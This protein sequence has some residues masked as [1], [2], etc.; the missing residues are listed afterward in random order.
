MI[1]NSAPPVRPDWNAT[2]AAAD[3]LRQLAL[4]ILTRVLTRDGATPDIAA[5]RPW[6]AAP[7]PPRHQQQ[8]RERLAVRFLVTEVPALHPAGEMIAATVFGRTLRD[9]LADAAGRLRRHD[10]L[11][12]RSFGP[13]A[14]LPL[15]HLAFS[16]PGFRLAAARAVRDHLSLRVLF[17]P[18]ARPVAVFSTPVLLAL[19]TSALAEVPLPPEEIEPLRRLGRRLREAEAW[20]GFWDI[21]LLASAEASG[22]TLPQDLRAV[23]KLASNLTQGPAETSGDGDAVPVPHPCLRADWL[24]ERPT[25]WAFLP[26]LPE[27]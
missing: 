19:A 10:R 27:S 3:A 18:D 20:A 13:D 16:A 25:W 17:S 14:L 12:R 26:D 15:V 1:S 22:M 7:R 9:R 4:A 23:A 2:D 5:L 11:P 6:L 24:D 21:W 8:A